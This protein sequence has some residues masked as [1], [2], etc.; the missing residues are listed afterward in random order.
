M[1]LSKDFHGQIL[2]KVYLRMGGPIDIEQ[3]GW[4]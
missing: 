2:K 4:E 3:M 1:V